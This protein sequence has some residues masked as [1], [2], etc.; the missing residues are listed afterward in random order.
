M[1]KLILIKSANTYTPAA[2]GEN[3]ILIGGGKI[4]LIDKNIKHRFTESQVEI[5]DGKNL[6]AIPG[7]IDGHI[8]IA[9]AGGEGGPIT[10]TPELPVSQL[11]AAGITTV[12]GC[13]GT[14]GITRNV[15]SVL[16]KAK[17][18]K[19]HGLSAWMY[20]GSYQVPAPT[21]T[22][23]L[24]S[25]ITM[26]EEIIGAG[27]IAIS[28]HRSSFPSTAEL[29]RLASE[30]RVAGMLAGKA[31]II[32]LHMGDAKNPFQPIY[33]A[34]QKS[35]LPLKQFLPTH[36]NRNNYIFEDA[37]TYGKK[38]Y[39]DIT[40]S[41]YPFFPDLEIKPSKAVI[42]L[43]NAGVPPEHITFT[44]DANGSLPDFDD[45]GRLLKLEK[46]DA[47]TILL[48]IRDLIAEGFDPEKAISLATR[49]VRNILKINH[50]GEIATGLDADILLCDNDWKPAYVIANGNIM[51]R[52]YNLVN[53]GGIN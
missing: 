50:K 14:D 11:V 53:L 23:S 29:I 44:S 4:L 35:E 32:N 42:E 24:A 28:D 15:A 49:N 46:G 40:T 51:I 18:I 31:G 9:G 47:A 48:E 2:I 8:H 6:N 3:D 13:L 25:D 22:G 1:N 27:E 37:K 12:V 16:M 26:I 52:N 36:C 20:T 45:E 21:L 5:I 30:V 43:V 17:A 10:R 41:A 39:V 34:I 33:D 7:L 19:A 38:G